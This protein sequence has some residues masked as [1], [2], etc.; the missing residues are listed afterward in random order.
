MSDLAP[1][2]VLVKFFSFFVFDS[3]YFPDDF[4]FE[5]IALLSFFNM[6]YASVAI[7]NFMPSFSPFLSG[8]DFS[9]SFL[10]AYFISSKGEP[11]FIAKTWYASLVFNV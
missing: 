4:L 2:F 7:L 5:F 9:A 8:C 11:G 3:A 10:Y 6:W 1:Q